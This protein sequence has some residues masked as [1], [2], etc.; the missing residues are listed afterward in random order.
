[1]CVGVFFN[2]MRIGVFLGGAEGG[3]GGTPYPPKGGCFS[4]RLITFGIYRARVALPITEEAVFYPN[5]LA[6]IKSLPEQ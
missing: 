6:L 2:W 4:Y 3:E 1:M 5:P